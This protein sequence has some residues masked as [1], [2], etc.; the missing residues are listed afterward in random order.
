MVFYARLEGY[1]KSPSTIHFQYIV[2]YF[3]RPQTFFSFLFRITCIIAIGTINICIYGN[4]K[5]FYMHWGSHPVQ[6]E[7]PSLN[8]ILLAEMLRIGQTMI[9]WYVSLLAHIG[10]SPPPFG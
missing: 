3:C 5:G 9:S 8:A 1:C 2:C 10:T 4:Y 6:Q 7:S